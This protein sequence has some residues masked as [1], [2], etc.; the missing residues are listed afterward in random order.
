MAA[1]E[2]NL[3]VS[4]SSF[5]NNP[6]YPPPPGWTLQHFIDGRPPEYGPPAGYANYAQPPVYAPQPIYA[7]SPMSAAAAAYAQPTPA[8]D[9][10]GGTA[11]TGLVIS[12]IAL[13]L[14]AVPYCGGVFVGLGLLFSALGLI[15]RKRRV[16]AII[17]LALSLLAI[18]IAIWTSTSY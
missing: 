4:G 11:I 13:L 10:M 6:E 3:P 15:S 16:M 5:P 8:P 18:G 7:P 17:G 2:P 12:I 9:S 14:S 1:E